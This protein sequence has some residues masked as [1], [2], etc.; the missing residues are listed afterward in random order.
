MSGPEI[1]DKIVECSSSFQRRSLYSQEK[2][3]MKKHSKYSPTFRI[4]R[5]KLRH[6]IQMY[7]NKPENI[8][9]L[10]ID[11]LS[12]LLRMSGVSHGSKTIV[13]D[14]CFGAVLLAV[15]QRIGDE[16]LI[17]DLLDAK[18]IAKTHV[19][20]LGFVEIKRYELARVST[21]SFDN[22]KQTLSESFGETTELKTGQ[23][24]PFSESGRLS[25]ECIECIKEAQF[26]SVIIASK[27]HPQLLL[28][29][30]FPILKPGALFA[31]YHRC[32][33][34]LRDTLQAL[35]K[36]GQTEQLTVTETWMRDFQVLPNRTH[37]TVK[38]DGSDSYILS[39]Y[40]VPAR[41][42]ELYGPVDLNK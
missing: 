7:D 14:S 6:L 41:V 35:E 27:Y 5:I 24:R 33:E 21:C 36:S 19:K 17:L 3:L 15:H 38:M 4:E 39:G 20:H 13:V 40:Y 37:P 16:G 34:I 31:V 11:S 10:K 30:L 28:D 22:L 8:M 2:Y 1:I 9:H 26:E 23:K 25:Q 18:M 32:R 42:L 12:L 29:I